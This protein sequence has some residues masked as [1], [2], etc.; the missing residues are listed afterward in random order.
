M[1]TI[2]GVLDSSETASDWELVPA[3]D[4]WAWA[5]VESDPGNLALVART[6]GEFWNSEEDRR[7]D[8]P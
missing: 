5:N 1:S 7:Y 6:W 2:G 3:F 8:L 4:S